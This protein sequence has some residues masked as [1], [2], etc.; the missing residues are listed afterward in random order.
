MISWRLLRALCVGEL[1][2]VCLQHAGLTHL[3]MPFVGFDMYLKLGLSWDFVNVGAF[4]ERYPECE[5]MEVFG[6]DNWWSI[7]LVV[8]HHLRGESGLIFH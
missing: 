2:S 5:L 3:L 1:V 6:K 7:G 8:C 4:A